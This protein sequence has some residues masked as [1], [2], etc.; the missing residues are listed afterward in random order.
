MWNVRT[1]TLLI[2]FLLTV[3]LMTP[4]LARPRLMPTGNCFCV[5]NVAGA[6]VGAVYPPRCRLQHL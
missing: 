3:V 2:A 6:P 4:T 1:L 5:C